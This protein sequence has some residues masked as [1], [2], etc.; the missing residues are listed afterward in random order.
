MNVSAHGCV[1]RMGFVSAKR[2]QSEGRWLTSVAAPLIDLPKRHLLVDVVHTC[3]GRFVLLVGPIAVS[4]VF[5]TN[6]DSCPKV[7]E[8]VVVLTG[9]GQ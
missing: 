8:V 2:H 6:V 4:L 1:Y 9:V 7:H 3:L 5:F